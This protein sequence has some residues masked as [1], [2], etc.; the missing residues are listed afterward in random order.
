[1]MG[2][3]FGNVSPSRQA[4]SCRRNRELTTEQQDEIVQIFK[5]FDVNGGGS[6]TK[7]ELKEALWSLGQQPS[8]EEMD[9][10]F[11]EHDVDQTGSLDLNDF[12][13]LMASRLTYENT[14]EEFAEAFRAIDRNKDGKLDI[15]E[16]NRLMVATGFGL[17]KDEL[18]DIFSLFNRDGSG[19]VDLEEFMDYMMGT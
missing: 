7:P 11:R 15:A 13:L 9:G 18:D 19:K 2:R 12:K 16:L 1:M 14:R 6:V 8:E 3:L 17:V 10:M 4:A 5:L